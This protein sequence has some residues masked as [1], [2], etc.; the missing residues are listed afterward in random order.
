MNNYQSEIEYYKQQLEKL[1]FSKKKIVFTKHFATATQIGAIISLYYIFSSANLTPFKEDITK[2]FF[3]AI[4]NFNEQ[5]EHSKPVIDW[6]KK[7]QNEE[8]VK[9]LIEYNTPYEPIENGMYQKIHYTYSYTNEL[10]ENIKKYL[11]NP[12]LLNENLTKEC[13]FIEYQDTINEQENNPT[14]NV[15]ILNKEKST[16]LYNKESKNKN[17]FYTLIFCLST[18]LLMS[19]LV[20]Y[21]LYYLKKEAKISLEEL[22]ERKRELEE[23]KKELENQLALIRKRQND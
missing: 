9:L 8:D 20:T 23:H 15:Q 16:Y 10:E 22:E 13:E 18:M 19:P 2:Y 11:S 6:S 21:P 1:K 12:K 14:Y 7:Y 4:E 17:R 3:P 5:K